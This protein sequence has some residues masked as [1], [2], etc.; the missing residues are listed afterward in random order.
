MKLSKRGEYALRSLIN[1]GIAAKVGRSLVRVS[2]RDGARAWIRCAGATL[3]VIRGGIDEPE[4]GWVSPIY[5]RLDPSTTLRARVA[6]GLPITIVTIV[7]D[8]A[9]PPP[10]VEFS[11]SVG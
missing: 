8:S 6:A 9:E 2:H 5:G 1:L 3:D 4:L 7:T 11:V 10:V